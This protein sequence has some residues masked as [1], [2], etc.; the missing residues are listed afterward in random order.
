MRNNPAKS[1]R[2]FLSLMT[3]LAS[4]VA[5][6]QAV[7]AQ[8]AAPAPAWMGADPSVEG[9]PL[10]N[11]AMFE[12]AMGL[13]KRRG[14]DW[15]K[16][17]TDLIDRMAYRLTLSNPEDMANYAPLN[18]S[19]KSAFFGGDQKNNPAMLA[20]TEQKLARFI[21]DGNGVAELYFMELLSRAAPDRDR[22]GQTRKVHRRAAELGLFDS[23]QANHARSTVLHY[24]RSYNDSGRYQESGIA[25]IETMAELENAKYSN[26]SPNFLGV[27]GETLV[28]IGQ[29]D[30]AERIFARLLAYWENADI[31]RR[32]QREGIWR[33]HNQHSYYLNIKGGFAQ[34]E[35]PGRIAAQMAEELFGINHIYTQKSRYNFAASLLGQGKAAEALPY[36]EEA[37]PLQLESE[38]QLF[39]GSDRTDTII[40]LTTLARARA[41][42]KG[43]E[44]GALEAAKDA[45]D[46][47]RQQR[48]ARLGWNTEPGKAVSGAAALAKAMARGDRRNPLS[49]AF[50]MVLFAGWAARDQHD[51]ALNEAFRAAQDLVLSD[52]GEA[53]SQAAA[54][55]LA[56]DGPLGAVVRQRQD[57]A[58]AI[59]AKTETYRLEALKSDSTITAQLGAELEALAEQLAVLD[60]QLSRDFPEYAELILPN[61]VDL[62]KAQ[63]T[64]GRDEALLF[65]LPSEGHHYIFAITDKRANW[66]R[67]D[68][69]AGEVAALVGRLKCRL[70]EVTCNADEQ[71]AVMQEEDSGASSPIDD[72]YPRFDVAASYRLYSALIAPV[73]KALRGKK[74][75]YVVASGPIGALPLAALATSPVK[76]AAQPEQLQKVPWLGNRHA[77]VTLPSVSALGVPRANLTKGTGSNRFIGYGAPSL[78]G[79]PA[80][81]AMRGTTK[82]RRGGSAPLRASGFFVSTGDTKL[83]V[84]PGLLRKLD[85]LPGTEREL[86]SLAAALGRDSS[87]VHIGDA[88]TE[89][90]VKQD[91]ALPAADVLV[92]ATHGL[93][94]GE[95]GQSAEPGLVLTPPGRG[96]VLDDGLLT[97]SE[98]AALRLNAR[99][100]IL[101]ACN[102]ATADSAP[103]S[104]ALSG[105]AR[106]FLYAGA[107]S[108]L[109]SHWRVSDDAS[110]ALTVQAVQAG[111]RGEKQA[112]A[113]QSAQRAVRS[114]KDG[115]GRRLPDWKPHWAHPSAWAPFTLITDRNR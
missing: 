75:V 72:F 105:L 38:K 32:K 55:D 17:A 43:N 27:L 18:A 95:M 12:D 94:P 103:G 76:N 5:L 74:T 80:S 39:S 60:T 14:D 88:A 26:I 50:D 106:S 89:T 64:L 107:Q 28:L 90:A 83:Q 16:A 13:R 21:A 87:A 114:G 47:L 101:S 34:A 46:R 91:E 69:G 53:I 92:F 78:E 81:A 41:Q 35:A 2:V 8:P 86:D 36:F 25:M 29:F 68:D 110:A 98:A 56:G 63:A 9:S 113:L 11:R 67:M 115:L 97:A 49:P 79:D 65:L 6:P 51:D 73:A 57:A 59:A 3:C 15:H 102:T 82:R 108:L 37:L 30:Q 31:D 54:R 99:W 19:V 10:S 112:Q 20:P 7:S 77:F 109:A 33:T 71:F 66:H 52:A 70:D 44:A 48:A 96:N 62:A 93:L 1:E 85:P 4:A 45:A 104:D 61:A 100:V 111:N 58:N 40:L 42:V 24:A 22:L 84:D 23:L